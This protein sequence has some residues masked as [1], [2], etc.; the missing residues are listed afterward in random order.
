MVFLL[1]DSQRPE[2]LSRSTTIVT[3]LVI[4][5]KLLI[6]LSLKFK[7]HILWNNAVEEKH[8]SESFKHIQDVAFWSISKNS[9]SQRTSVV[10]THALGI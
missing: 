8:Y 2:K 9:D 4:V 3:L 5:A 10:I 6:L 1:S 7:E